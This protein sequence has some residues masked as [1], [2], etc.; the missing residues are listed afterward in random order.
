MKGHRNRLM[1]STATVNEAELIAR[2]VGGESE[3]YAYFLHHYGDAVFHLIV[4]LV[5]NAEDAEE[6]R[7][8]TFLRAYRGLVHFRGDSSF[9]TWVLRIAYNSALN[10]L[11]KQRHTEVLFEEED[12]LVD[13]EVDDALEDGL[14]AL[15]SRRVEVLHQAIERLPVADRVLITEFYLSGRPLKE[16]AYVLDITPNAAAVRLLRIKKKLYHLIKHIGGHEHYDR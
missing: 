12:S 3:Q 13:K 14:E 9:K 5:G 1:D 11:R 7:Q 15:Q 8:D 10:F 4:R 2:I 6:L 16:V